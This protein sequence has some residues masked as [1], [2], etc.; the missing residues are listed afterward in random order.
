MNEVY[1]FLKQ[2]GV[3]YLATAEGDQPQSKMKIRKIK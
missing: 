1:D 2:C 3:Y